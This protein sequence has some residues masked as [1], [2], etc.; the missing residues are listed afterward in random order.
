VETRK[1]YCS[2]TYWSNYIDSVIES[3]K[4]DEDTIIDLLIYGNCVDA[5]ITM[6]LCRDEFPNYKITV[7]KVG[8]KT[9]LGE[10]D[11]DE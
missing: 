6:N 1:T 5:K 11:E 3:I 4:K 9:P 8:E 10:E 7:N 2:K